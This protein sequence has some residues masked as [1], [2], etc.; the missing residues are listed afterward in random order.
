[1]EWAHAELQE[2]FAV[3]VTCIAGQRAGDGEN[4]LGDLERGLGGRLVEEV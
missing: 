3:W 4:R 1:V 2:D